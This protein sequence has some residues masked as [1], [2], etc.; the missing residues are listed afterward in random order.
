MSLIL[1]AF[2]NCILDHHPF[3]LSGTRQEL[4]C[5]GHAAFWLAFWNC[6]L[7]YHLFKVCC[8]CQQDVDCESR[9]K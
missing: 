2:W 6:I 7:D 8:L 4:Y 3:N 9:P 5:A 1:L